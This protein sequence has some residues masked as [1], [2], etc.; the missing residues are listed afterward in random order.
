MKMFS[1]ALVFCVSAGGTAAWWRRRSRRSWGTGGSLRQW[2][3]KLPVSSSSETTMLIW[4]VSCRGLFKC[5]SFPF[6]LHL[7][8]ILLLQCPQLQH[9]YSPSVWKPRE[10]KYHVQKSHIFTLCQSHVLRTVCSSDLPPEVITEANVLYFLN[11]LLFIDLDNLFNWGCI[12]F[13]GLK[14]LKIF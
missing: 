3:H 11:L 13:R 4:G 14:H 2:W 9:L 12:E 8:L 7:E 6:K 5:A 10:N 1:C